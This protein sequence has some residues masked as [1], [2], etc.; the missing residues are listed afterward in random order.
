MI[1]IQRSLVDYQREV[2]RITGRKRIVWHELCEAIRVAD[3]A[4]ALYYQDEYRTL[5]LQ[6][7]RLLRLMESPKMEQKETERYV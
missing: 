6:E 1:A 2:E 5:T 3:V 7:D 4:G